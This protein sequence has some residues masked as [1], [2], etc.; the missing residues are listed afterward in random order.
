MKWG[1]VINVRLA[2]LLALI[3]PWQAFAG[4]SGC[5]QSAEVYDFGAGWSTL[6]ERYGFVLLMPQQEPSNNH[7]K[8]SGIYHTD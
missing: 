6:A 5:T 2:L 3:L 1:R 7:Q 8:L 4:V